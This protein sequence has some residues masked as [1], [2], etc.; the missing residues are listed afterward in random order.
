MKT[1][2]ALGVLAGGFL[3]A[4]APR[5]VV[6]TVLWAVSRT[7]PALG[8]LVLVTLAATWRRGDD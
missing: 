1:L 5:A 8:A 6:A 2:S 7:H 3:F 4:P